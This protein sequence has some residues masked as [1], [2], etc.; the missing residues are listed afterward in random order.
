M[1]SRKRSQRLKSIILGAA[2]VGVVALIGFGSHIQAMLGIHPEIPA[3]LKGRTAAAFEVATM[4]GETLRFPKD[5]AG[6]LVLLDFWATWCPPCVASIPHVREAHEQYAS[7]GLAVVSISLDS[8]RVSEENVRQFVE[9]KQ[10]NWP[11]VYTGAGRIADMYGVDAIPAMFLI[12]GDSGAIIAGG[13]QLDGP[14]IKRTIEEAL[15]R[16]GG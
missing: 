13:R 12:D 14:F 16:K 4:Q 6:R 1:E 10:M 8:P 7:R 2:F 3:E 5:F 11:Q 15:T 9:R